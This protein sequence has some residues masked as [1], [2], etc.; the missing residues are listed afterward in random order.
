MKVVPLLTFLAL[1]ASGS[2]SEANGSGQP[3]VTVLDIQELQLLVIDGVYEPDEIIQTDVAVIGGGL[4]GFAA[5]MALGEAG[6]Q[7]VWTEETDWL[8]GQLTSQGV[9]APD[10]NLH[11]EM[12]GGTMAYQEFRSHIRKWYRRHRRLSEASKKARHFS[13]GNCWVSRLSFEPKVALSVLDD[14]IRP[15]RQDG[16]LRVLKRHKPFRANSSDDR[17]SWIDLLDFEENKIRRIEADL[18]LDATEL[19]DLWPLCDAEYTIGAESVAETGE[20]H[21]KQD[22]PQ[23]DCVQSFTYPFI[24]EYHPGEN[25]S[26]PKPQGY[27]KFKAKQPYDYEYAHLDDRGDS[28]TSRPNLFEAIPGRPGSLWTYRRLIDRQAFQEGEYATDYSLINWPSLDSRRNLLDASPAE[29]LEFLEEA[30][31]ISL[32]FLYWMQNELSHRKGVG[33]PGLKLNLDLMGTEDGLS[34]F[35]Y[36]REARRAK[37]LATLREQD[38]TVS[39]NPDRHYGRYFHDSI[40]IGHYPLDIHP[41]NCEESLPSSETSTLP[42][43][44]PLGVLVPVRMENLIPAGKSAGTTHITSS[45]TRLHP[46][47]WAMGEAA[48][49]LALNCLQEDLSPQEIHADSTLVRGL[50]EDLVNRRIPIQWSPGVSPSDPHFRRRQWRALD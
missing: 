42:F 8:G 13:P 23:R 15:Y 27:E 45:C 2:I 50:Q 38:V 46:I 5:V 10:E 26:I 40:G 24:L 12:G 49:V 21:A 18:F 25:H 1:F 17:V 20:P 43:Q 9:S 3:D 35:P 7:V 22:A 48:G 29:M 37:T 33:Y 34:K 36:I 41:G 11:I 16:H 39:A 31:N 32:G 14:W 19:G 44:I 4:G 28:S 30:K 6:I 47:E